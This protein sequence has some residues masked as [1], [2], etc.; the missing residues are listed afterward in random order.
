MLNTNGLTATLDQNIE[1]VVC[2]IM[3][4]TGKHRISKP[5]LR[6]E[7]FL[8]YATQKF[9]VE[10]NLFY[11]TNYTYGDVMYFIER[12]RQNITAALYA[13]KG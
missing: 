9:W 10:S 5:E 8:T 7:L 11:S 2:E 3:R 4:H 1:V 6:I 12:Y 13:A